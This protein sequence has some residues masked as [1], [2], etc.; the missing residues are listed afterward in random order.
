MEVSIR[1][2]SE[3]ITLTIIKRHCQR[4]DE[5][6]LHEINKASDAIR[7]K[8]QL[9]QERTHATDKALNDMWKPVVTLLKKWVDQEKAQSSDDQTDDPGTSA[10]HVWTSFTPK[11][12]DKVHG[13][14]ELSRG[15]QKIGS[16]L[17]FFG[18]DK[19]Y[20]GDGVYPLSKGLLELLFKRIPDEE[21][22]KDQDLKHYKEI[23][24]KSNAHR[25]QN[26]P[27]GRLRTSNVPKF[28][29]ISELLGMRGAGLRSNLLKAMIDD[30][31]SKKNVNKYDDDEDSRG[32][33]VQNQNDISMNKVRE[34]DN[35]M[36]MDE[37]EADSDTEDDAQEEGEEE[38]DEDTDK[39]GG[40]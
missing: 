1:V 16:K 20:I 2:T 14:R 18:R 23:L 28:R 32:S 17:V 13:I 11:Q 27:S 7:K 21:L 12:L 22:I 9:L 34:D 26:R 33:T 38:D 8:Y 4:E 19:V 29:L 37:E 31:I 6:V 36:D 15:R 35:G 39:E 40:Q 3:E 24:L 10:Q 30:L 5:S 25:V